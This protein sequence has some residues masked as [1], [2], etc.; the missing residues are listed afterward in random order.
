MTAKLD[1]YDRA[2][3]RQQPTPAVAD[4]AANR[5]IGPRADAATLVDAFGGPL[6]AHG[7]DPADVI[8]LLADGRRAGLM[9][10][11]SGRFFGWVIGGT[12]PAALAA[13]WLVSAWDQN[14]GHALR[15][16]GHGGGRGG[17]RGRGC[18]TCSGCRPAPT[19]A[20][21]PARR[22]PT[23]P[24]WP[25]AR[26]QVLAEAGWD[27]DEHGPDGCAAGPRAGR[28]GAARHGRPGAA[29]PRA[30][31]AAAGRRRRAGPDP[32]RRAGARRSP[33]AG[34]GPVIVCLQAGNLHSGAFDPFGRAIELAHAARRAGCTSTARS[35]CG[36]R[37]R[38][39]CAT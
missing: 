22:W 24:A 38:R 11:P 31:R 7:D 28:R 36:R 33:A 25:P 8:D 6:P 9:A 12:L 10:M 21:S 32:G 16:A 30:R 1:A 19:S 5:P 35:G 4:F 26:Q 23:S 3:T 29:L 27:V 13:D 18:S 15:H 17:G 2:L 14:A 20:S 34:A 39:A 37:P